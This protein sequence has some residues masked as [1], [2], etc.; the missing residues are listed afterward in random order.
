ML[1]SGNILL[2]DGVCNL[3]NGLVRFIIRRDPDAIIKFASLQSPAGQSLLERFDLSAKEI[4]SVVYIT[5]DK[6]YL[7][8][9]A[10]LHLLKEL[11]GGWRLF[12]GFIIIPGFIRDFF[13]NLIAVN[14]YR[15]FGKTDTCMVPA[16]DI[17]SRFLL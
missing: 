12:Y 17:M 14:R 8:S 2:F 3:C 6:R 1:T 15:I 9:S 16:P 5:G 7:K 13:Y 10:I 11:G 4:D